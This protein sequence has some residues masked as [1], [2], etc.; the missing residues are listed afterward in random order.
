MS[1]FYIKEINASG[2]DVK[3]S[4][5]SLK[6][7]LNIIYGPSNTGKSYVV[8]C[9]NFMFGSNNSEIPFTK[10][11]TG[12]DTVNMVMESDDGYSISMTRKIVD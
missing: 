11:D 1:R 8:K 7:G 2:P 4:T 5:I 10:E 9:I 3:Y 12:Y 6:D